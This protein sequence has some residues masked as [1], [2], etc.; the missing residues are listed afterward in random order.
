M[1]I[2]K[3]A[4]PATAL[5][6]ATPAMAQDITVPEGYTVSVA[7][8]GE[9]A[10]RHIAFNANGDLYVSS[11]MGR[12]EGEDAVPAGIL[13]MRDS[14][15]DGVFDQSQHFGDVSGTGLRFHN[16]DLYATS[17]TDLYR[18]SFA[19]DD[20]VPAGA[21]EVIVS[22]MPTGGY[23]ARPIAFDGEGRVLLAIGSGGNTC[24]DQPGPEGRPLNPC[25]Q[26]EDR[27]G[28]WRFDAS[29]AGQQHPADGE[30]IATGLRDAQALAWNPA[31]GFAYTVL[32]GRNG[33]N[34]AGEQQFSEADSQLGVAEEMHRVTEG[35]DFGWP[36]THFDGRTMQRF[37]APEYGGTPDTSVTD[38]AY[39][40]PVAVLPPHSSP[41]DIVF[42]AEGRFPGAFKGGAFVALQGGFNGPSP[43]NGYSVWFVPQNAGVSFGEPQ[44]F[45]DGF[46]GGDPSSAGSTARPSGLAISPDGA[47]YVVDTKSGKIWRIAVAG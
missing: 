25:P 42:D 18:Y 16:G 5:A 38:S 35:A 23:S 14:D 40:T 21:P 30:H 9:G 41:L 3:Y 26:L 39:A 22:G 15:G 47:L 29:A 11:R 43:Q 2:W 17:A 13:A 27:A 44:V 1:T 32:Q 19:G 34:R 6:I 7:Y 10:A 20:L 33:L 31:D 36:Y 24:T 8:E 12:G 28:I 4:L 46:D 37:G 45:A